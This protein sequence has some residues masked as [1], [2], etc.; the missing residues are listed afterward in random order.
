MINRGWG[1]KQYTLQVKGRAW[2]HL[3][4][5][6]RAVRNGKQS[7]IPAHS[8]VEPMQMKSSMNIHL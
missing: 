4:G 8:S 5:I 7:D 6:H 2:Y 3:H 1:L